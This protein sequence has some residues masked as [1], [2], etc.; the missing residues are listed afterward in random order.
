MLAWRGLA[1]AYFQ[2][3]GRLRCFPVQDAETHCKSGVPW[4]VL[5]M[6]VGLKRPPVQKGHGLASG[7]GEFWC[8]QSAVDSETPAPV[9]QGEHCPFAQSSSCTA[10][11]VSPVRDISWKLCYL[12]SFLDILALGFKL[13]EVNRAA[14]N[15]VCVWDWVGL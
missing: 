10:I 3:Q 11:S 13:F 8:S 5:C 12:M 6:Y 7:I 4:W 2:S 1:D 9:G 14:E 15:M